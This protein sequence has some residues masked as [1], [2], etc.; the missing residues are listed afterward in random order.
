MH[1]SRS[2]LEQ[3]FERWLNNEATPA[4]SD[5]LLELIEQPGTELPPLMK[6]AWEEMQGGPVYTTAEKNALADRI[7][8]K[9]S[10][11]RPYYWAA[12]AMLALLVTGAAI[13]MGQSG[14]RSPAP[15]STVAKND[16][17]LDVAPGKQ[18]ALLTLANGQTIALDSLNNGVIANQNGTQVLMNNGQLSYDAD[19]AESV[20]YNT[21][22]TP[23]GRKFMLVLPDETKVWLNAASSLRYPTAFTGKERNVEITGEAYFEVAKNNESPFTV[24]VENNTR[25]IVLGTHF[26][27]KAYNNET[28]TNTT[29]LEG[30]VLIQSGAQEQRIAPGQQARVSKGA[31]KVL[32]DVDTRQAIAWKEGYFNFNG[33][34]LADVM[35]QL[36][37]WYD[38]DVIYQGKIPELTFDGELP[39]TLQL[40]QML[41]ILHKVEV[42]YRIEEGKR[43]IILP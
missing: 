27:I 9:R 4:E 28:S 39:V 34:S 2:R 21:I 36:E 38:I 40:S 37:R 14:Q 19:A 31:I 35:R 11:P 13:W 8:Q 25:V 23:R 20:S 33:T 12:A 5:E 22:R 43:L 17:T 24:T 26:N 15:P 41:R 30:A 6:K 10:S 29:L 7:L 42:K 16:T 1:S 32:H 3:L 18:G